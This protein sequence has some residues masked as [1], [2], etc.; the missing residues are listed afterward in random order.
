[1]QQQKTTTYT[2]ATVQIGA[3]LSYQPAGHVG[4]ACF[5]DLSKTL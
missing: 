3:I 5:D 1:M 2:N 4:L